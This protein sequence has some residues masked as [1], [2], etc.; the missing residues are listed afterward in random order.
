MFALLYHIVTLCSTRCAIISLVN[1][2][3]DQDQDLASQ[4]QDQDQDQDFLAKTKARLFI[5]RSRPSQ[6]LFVEAQN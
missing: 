5:S 3:Q 2:D 1:Q 4:D 6:R